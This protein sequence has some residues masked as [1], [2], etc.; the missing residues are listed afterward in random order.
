MLS[1]TFF[2]VCVSFFPF[3]EG[4]VCDL[5]VLV[6][7]YCSSFKYGCSGW[8]EPFMFAHLYDTFIRDTTF[9]NKNER[10]GT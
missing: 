6:P 5:V 8:S 9:L 7:D 3:F 1:S 10:V 4:G 2:N